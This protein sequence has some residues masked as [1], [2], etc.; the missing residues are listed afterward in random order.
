MAK[1]EGLYQKQ[2]HL[3]VKGQIILVISNRSNPT[4]RKPPKYLLQRFNPKTHKYISSLYPVGGAVDTYI[5]DHAGKSYLLKI[6]SETEAQITPNF[7]V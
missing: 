2:K 4:P 7:T 6:H 3:L 5:F 1:I